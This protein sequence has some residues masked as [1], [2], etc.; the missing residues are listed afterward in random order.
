MSKLVLFLG[1]IF[2]GC[3]ILSGAVSAA[4]VKIS[5][6]TD[7]IKNSISTAHSGDTLN[8]TAGVYNEHDLVVNKNLTIIGPTVTGNNTPTAII[9]G[10]NLGRVFTIDSGAHVTLKYLLI[11]NGNA[12][13][14][15]TNPHGGGVL[16]MGNSTLNLVNCTLKNNIAEWG[17]G[18]CNEQ[19]TVTITDSNLNNNNV[20]RGGG[21]FN[22]GTLT[23]TGSNIKN[24]IVT[25]YG[26]GISN[27]EGNLTVINCN[28]NNNT[29]DHGGGLSN[30]E[31]NLTVFNS[32]ISGNTAINDGGG[33]IFNSANLKLNNSSINNNIASYGGGIYN[34]ANV[35]LTNSFVNNN[36]AEF[37]GGIFNNQETLK[38]SSSTIDYNSAS[39]GGAIDNCQGIISIVYSQIVG[40]T[41]SQ[42]NAIFNYE[43][44][45]NA[46]SNW[47][48]SNNNPSSKVYGDVNITPWLT[49]PLVVTNF[50]PTNNAIKVPENEVI[51]VTFN[52]SIKT[53]SN[54]IV[55][56][57]NNGTT[58]P[59]STSIN[60]NIL[61]IK[62]LASLNTGKYNL[63]LHTG[64]ITDLT[65]NKLLLTGIIFNTN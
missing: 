27:N 52:E 7:A 12:T 14:D 19:G 33:G 45:A 9:N 58:I 28:I 4:T 48:G 65:G 63:I 41:A 13:T 3:I 42:G 50:V 60:N 18:V 6:G 51:T 24:N 26:G 55:L 32:I 57:N 1:L 25:E 8:L 61:T 2:L 5:P 38:L 34:I 44:T 22:V 47:W 40:N 16:N 29:A 39:K 23:V 31:G 56:T 49:T 35:T 53:G 46:E 54:W 17:G 43:G 11:L 36:K 10:Q 37:G 20:T 30:N 21:I 59:I 15:T 62:P 64:S